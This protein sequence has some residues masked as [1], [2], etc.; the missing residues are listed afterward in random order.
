MN[1]TK[2][3]HGKTL[4]VAHRGCSAL[5]RENTNAAFVAA[6]NRSHWGIETDVHRTGDGQFVVIHDDRTGRVCAVDLPVETT[7]FERLRS[8][9][10][11]D[12]NGRTDRADLRIP[13]LREYVATCKKYEKTGVLE[14]KSRFTD[15]EIAGIIDVIRGEDYLGGIVFIAFDIENLIKVRAQLPGHPCQL[16]TGRY[17]AKLLATLKE[18]ALDLDIEYHAL[19]EEALSALH[20]AGVRVNVWTV[21]DPAAAETFVKWG[22]DYITS[23]CLE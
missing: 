8:L 23:N 4:M 14:L 9:T 21:D 16:L 1:T 6:G 22:V 18:R 5:E 17:D 7:S 13:T 11:T 2:V 20:E 12:L 19:T 10:L 15:D 3:N